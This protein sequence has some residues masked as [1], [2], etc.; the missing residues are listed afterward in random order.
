MIRI[1]VSMANPSTSAGAEKNRPFSRR[2]PTAAEVRSTGS[3]GTL[4]SLETAKVALLHLRDSITSIEFQKLLE[5][6]R[7]TNTTKANKNSMASERSETSVIHTEMDTTT[8]SGGGST[9]RE[10]NEQLLAGE[11]NTGS[12]SIESVMPGN[13]YSTVDHSQWNTVTRDNLKRKKGSD[14]NGSKLSDASATGIGT[15]TKGR[16]DSGLIVYLKGQDSDI[17]KEAIVGYGFVPNCKLN[18][19]DY[20]DF[21]IR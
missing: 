17:A 16:V 9:V 2:P 15:V 20:L 1:F 8:S 11:G 6:M 12:V 3:N 10:L 5:D 7:D 18:I 19:G 4:F 13:M 14:S 21:L